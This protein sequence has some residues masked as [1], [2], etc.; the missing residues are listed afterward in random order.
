MQFA[1]NKCKV[2]R[3]LQRLLTPFDIENISVEKEAFSRSFS[4]HFEYLK[5]K[6]PPEI[7]DFKRLRK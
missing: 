4:V 7:L 3:G 5:K 1:S 2:N 6:K